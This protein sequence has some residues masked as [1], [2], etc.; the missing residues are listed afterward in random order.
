M[1]GQWISNAEVIHGID[2]PT[3]VKGSR[4]YRALV[5]A[6]GHDAL[7]DAYKLDRDSHWSDIVTQAYLHG[8]IE[9]DGTLT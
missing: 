2:D 4:A 5:Q 8:D 1:T 3:A 7:C 9:S 6:H